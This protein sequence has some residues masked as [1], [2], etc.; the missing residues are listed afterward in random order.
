MSIHQV[1]EY[2]TKLSVRTNDNKWYAGQL[3]NIDSEIR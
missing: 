2:S 1:S 3:L